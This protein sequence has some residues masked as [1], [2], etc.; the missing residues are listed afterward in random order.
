MKEDNVEWR[1]GMSR[2]EI[3][4]DLAKSY[5][6]LFSMVEEV[7]D[8]RD[9]KSIVELDLSLDDLKSY[10]DSEKETHYED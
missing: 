2:E 6:E 5:E 4:Q 9:N 7:L 8:V 10:V 3:Y 1:A